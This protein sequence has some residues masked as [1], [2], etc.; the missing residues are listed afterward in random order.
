VDDT[1]I[2]CEANTDHLHHLCYIS[3]CFEVVLGLKIN[4]AKYELVLVGAVED[5]GGLV[6]IGCRVSS[7]PMKHLGLP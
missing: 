1:L 3:L 2:F 7:L 6:H 5:V 4:L